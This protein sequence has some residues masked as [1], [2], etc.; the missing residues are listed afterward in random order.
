VG[1]PSPQPFT[2]KPV[3]LCRPDE[4]R[5]ELARQMVRTPNWQMALHRALIALLIQEPGGEILR[6]VRD[7]LDSSAQKIPDRRT[8][9]ALKNPKPGFL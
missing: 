9:S 4:H 2:I 5:F 7:V 1:N 6:P 3:I 8:F